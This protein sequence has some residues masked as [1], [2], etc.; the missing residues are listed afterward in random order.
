MT[1]QLEEASEH[2]PV[3]WKEI[4]AEGD[5]PS[6]LREF[7]VHHNPSAGAAARAYDRLV[8]RVRRALG[9]PG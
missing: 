5:L 2:F 4:G 3:F 6:A 8:W 9:G 7:E 1:F